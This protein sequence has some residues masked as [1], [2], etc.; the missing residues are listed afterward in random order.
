MFL[1]VSFHP[2]H[3]QEFDRNEISKTVKEGRMDVILEKKSERK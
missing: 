2:I 3:Y 1:S